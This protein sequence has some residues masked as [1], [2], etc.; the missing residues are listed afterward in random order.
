ME[1]GKVPPWQKRMHRVW[2]DAHSGIGQKIVDKGK[3]KGQFTR[4]TLTNHGWKPYQKE[5]R[6]STIQW[7]LFKL[8]G[9]RSNHPKPRKSRVAAVAE[10]RRGDTSQPASHRPLAWSFME[11]EE[12]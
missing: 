5:I 6:V 9:G 11:D 8:A 2:A 12:L 4:C 7:K 3:A 1:K 10:D